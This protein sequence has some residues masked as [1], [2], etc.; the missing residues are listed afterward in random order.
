MP[1]IQSQFVGVRELQ[2]PFKY[3]DIDLSKK[4]FEYM[5]MK[6]FEESNDVT[7]LEYSLLFEKFV[8]KQETL[9]SSRAS[10]VFH[11]FLNFSRKPKCQLLLL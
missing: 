3:F 11:S 1:E 9:N 2:L 8:E 5:I 4:Q 7:K 10:K 6:L